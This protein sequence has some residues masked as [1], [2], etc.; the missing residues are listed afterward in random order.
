MSIAPPDAAPSATPP[1]EQA[2]APDDR[3]DAVSQL[4]EN[5]KAAIAD[6]VRWYRATKRPQIYGLAGYAGTGKTTVLKYVADALGIRVGGVTSGADGDAG[7]GLVVDGDI[8]AVAPTGRAAMI[9]QHAGMPCATIHSVIYVQRTA[10]ATRI[11]EIEQR[12][13][14]IAA[15]PTPGDAARREA[16]TLE[17][18]L[19]DL[20]SY[21]PVLNPQSA[22]ADAALVIVE[23]ASMV[24]ERLKKDLLSFG[25]PILAV[26]DPGQLAPVKDAGTSLMPNAGPFDFTLTEIHRQALDSGIIRLATDVRH[27]LMPTARSDYGGDVILAPTGRLSV[28]DYLARDQVI[29]HTRRAG[30]QLNVQMRRRLGFEG[31]LPTGESIDGRHERIVCLHNRYDLG[32]VNGQELRFGGVRTEES[33][34]GKEIR[35]ESDVERLNYRTGQFERLRCWGHDSEGRRTPIDI[36]RQ[37]VWRGGF[38][39]AD[40]AARGEEF[41]PRQRLWRS[42]GQQL[43][44]SGARGGRGIKATWAWALTCHKAQGGQWDAVLVRVEPAVLRH[45]RERWLYT[46]VTRARRRLALTGLRDG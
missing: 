17:R 38:S 27:G 45:D 1:S 25:R 30:W 29:V 2:G 28:D 13:A 8:L 33:S 43:D 34:P 23:E 24:G 22:I 36:A 14:E 15:A 5:Q 4:T 10:S 42:D 20:L 46:A 44:A 9:L 16:A 21:R 39:T 31:L 40:V 18:E 6:I 32:L 35:F 3:T 11:H 26:G 41:D 7:G 37:S 19:D 12:L